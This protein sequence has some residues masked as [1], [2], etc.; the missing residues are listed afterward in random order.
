[1]WAKLEEIK[2]IS[3]AIMLIPVLYN[4]G[5]VKCRPYSEKSDIAA[6]KKKHFKSDPFLKGH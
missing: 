6:K 4:Y 5:V 3:G 2:L 1:M